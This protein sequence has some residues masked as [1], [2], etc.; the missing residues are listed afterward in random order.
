MTH[1]AKQHATSDSSAHDQHIFKGAIQELTEKACDSSLTVV[2][3]AA[4]KHWRPQLQAPSGYHTG[5]A[6]DTVQYMHIMQL[7][8]P[9]RR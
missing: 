5:C 7:R 8:P 4:R 2:C 3:D 6:I 9:S 1:L